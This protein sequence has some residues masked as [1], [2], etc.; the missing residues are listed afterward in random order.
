MNSFHAVM[1][2]KRKVGASES[3]EHMGNCP[4]SS[5]SAAVVP[6][7]DRAHSNS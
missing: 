5:N 6:K 1:M 2:T 3:I 7:G 4:I